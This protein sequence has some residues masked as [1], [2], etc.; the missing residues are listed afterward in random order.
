M[1]EHIIDILSAT[2]RGSIHADTPAQPYWS[3]FVNSNH[4]LPPFREL[5]LS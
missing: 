5:P 1:T 2:L 3:H 4:E